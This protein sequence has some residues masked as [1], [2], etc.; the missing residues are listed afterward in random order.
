[1]ANDRRGVLASAWRKT[2]EK[3]MRKRPVPQLPTASR[4]DDEL[5]STG[6]LE[7]SRYQGLS[8]GKRSAGPR[9]LG[10]APPPVPASLEPPPPVDPPP[11]SVSVPPLDQQPAPS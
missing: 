10:S 1:M 3:S 11:L 6:R 2:I 8:A 7:T 4:M 9:V 5:E